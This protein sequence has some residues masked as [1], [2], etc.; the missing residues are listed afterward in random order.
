MTAPFEKLGQSLAGEITGTQLAAAVRTLWAAL[1]VEETLRRWSNEARR[2]APAVPVHDSVLREMES[3]LENLERAFRTN[4][5]R[6]AEWLPIVEAGLS[7][8]TVGVIPPALDQVLVGA[9]DRSRHPELRLALVLGLNEGVF[10]APPPRPPI[11]TESER[12]LLSHALEGS[13]ASLGLDARQRIAHERYYGYI[14]C[15]RSRERLILTCAAAN[16]QGAALHPSPFLAHLERLVPGVFPAEPARR[17]TFAAPDEHEAEHASEIASALVAGT[18]PELSALLDIK[19]L[20][21]IVD[22]AQQFRRASEVVRLPRELVA[23][24]FPPPFTTSVS[25]LEDFAACPFK[26]FVRH[27]LRVQE[28][29]HFDLDHRHK[30]IF[31]HEVLHTFHQRATAGGRRWRDWAPAEAA[32]LVREIG[33]GELAEYERGLFQADQARRFVGDILLDNLE[34]LVSTLVTWMA[35]YQFDP[36]AVELE[37]GLGQSAL[38]GWRLPL[39]DGREMLLCG[40]IDRIDV[41]ELDGQG[42]ALGVVIDYKSSGKKIDATKLHHGLELQLLSYLGFLQQLPATVPLRKL[43]PAGVFYVGLRGGPAAAGRAPRRSI[44][45][46]RRSAPASGTKAVSTAPGMPSSTPRTARSS[47]ARIT[48]RS[49]R[50][51]RSRN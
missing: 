16:S 12:T 24:L 10:P 30:G 23:T 15:T 20:G 28:R 2:V 38:P 32:A 25:A 11:L 8:L 4:G 1:E 5:L 37:F 3:W 31:Q 50:R 42:E 45:R 39:G 43:V 33:R 34:R 6:V 22:R 7:G 40:R 19:P 36:C 47:S 41:C 29:E 9:I 18:P 44:I 14:A 21:D 35:H 46:R 27:G 51:K 49:W 48:P 17:E 26:F 13:G